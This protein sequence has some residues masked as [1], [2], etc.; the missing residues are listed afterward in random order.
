MTDK[1]KRL[2]DAWFEAMQRLGPILAEEVEMA[3]GDM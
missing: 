3:G 1:L 2:R